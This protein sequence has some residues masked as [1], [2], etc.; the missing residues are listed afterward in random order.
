MFS[1]NF[2]AS[3]AYAHM[4]I[5]PDHACDFLSGET[6]IASCNLH[7]ARST[8]TT[9]SIS[10]FPFPIP[11]LSFTQL[12]EIRHSLAWLF[13]YILPLPVPISRGLL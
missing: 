6:S 12:P 4:Y 3:C 2:T 8:L 13:I 1:E 11:F 5:L 10:V 9:I 7:Q